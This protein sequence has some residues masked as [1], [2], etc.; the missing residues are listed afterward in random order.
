MP[1][2]VGMVF[3]SVAISYVQVSLYVGISMY[4]GELQVVSFL[5]SVYTYPPGEFLPEL[6]A[7]QLC[8]P[9]LGI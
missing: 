6:I 4:G 5:L 8:L 2:N 3:M 7:P 9:L 1:S